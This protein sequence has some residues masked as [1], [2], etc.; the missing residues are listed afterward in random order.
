MSRKQRRSAPHD[1][2]A[3]R[4]I[5]PGDFSGKDVTLEDGT[6][7]VGPAEPKAPFA[8]A[9]VQ[10]VE[11]FDVQRM[12]E[13]QHGKPG[14]KFRNIGLDETVDLRALTEANGGRPPQ[15]VVMKKN[16]IDNFKAKLTAADAGRM[17]HL[18]DTI[19]R[20]VSTLK[21]NGS[22][23]A[24]TQTNESWLRQPGPDGK[25]SIP[26]SRDVRKRIEKLK[27][28]GETDEAVINRIM[29]TKRV[30]LYPAGTEEYDLAVDMGPVLVGGALEESKSKEIAARLKAMPP[31]KRYNFLREQT[32]ELLGPNDGSDGWAEKLGM[33]MAFITNSL[34]PDDAR[35]LS[36]EI[37]DTLRPDPFHKEMDE[38]AK[39]AAHKVAQTLEKLPP[40]MAAEVVHN[41]VNGNFQIEDGDKKDAAMPGFTDHVT[42]HLVSSEKARAAIQ[43]ILDSDNENLKFSPEQRAKLERFMATG[44]KDIALE[45]T[46]EKRKEIYYTK[47][48][49]AK[50]AARLDQE[51]AALKKQDQAWTEIEAMGKNPRLSRLGE[52]GYHKAIQVWEDGSVIVPHRFVV[53]GQLESLSRAATV[54]VVQHDWSAAF[55]KAT[56]FSEGEFHLPYDDM[57]FEF[58]IG[59]RRV[60][61]CI[62]NDEAP[63]PPLCLLL[64][65]T[66]VGWTFGA[67][68]TITNGVWEFFKKNADACAPIMAVCQK[69]IRAVCIALE[70]QVVETELV[71]APHRLNRKRERAGK[72]P[73]FDHHIVNL[74]NRKRY[75]PREALPSDIEDEHPGKRL[76]FVRGHW[77]HYTNHK[78][79]IKW[80]LRG[81]PDLGFVDK[82]YRL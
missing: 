68:Y 51:E 46:N 41:M 20:L 7:K 1:N 32:L 10:R 49:L 21:A 26:V 22:E 9:N 66:S 12:L 64:I 57:V 37:A 54:F 48:R 47:E 30:P 63:H 44:D 79:W 38:V 74:A 13:M 8:T 24:I 69:Q 14:G 17:P 65:E 39:E 52:T 73:V 33:L 56:D 53:E 15:F 72:I 25:V 31:K 19:S 75:L 16:T 35:R 61:C 58:R 55:D 50:E 76:H 11:D 81:N 71:R 77:R 5:A 82:E 34:E 42:K 40:E 45:V 4:H 3:N 36:M 80:F 59:G 2:K 6:L 60:C 78:V 43:H 28:P 27:R 18:D 29:D 23:V 70:A 67:V 62:Q